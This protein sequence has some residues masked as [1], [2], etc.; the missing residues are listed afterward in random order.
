LVNGGS[1]ALLTHRAPFAAALERLDA[2]AK[3]DRQIGGAYRP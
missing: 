3:I 2:R 1:S